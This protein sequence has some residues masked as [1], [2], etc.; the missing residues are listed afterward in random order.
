MCARAA[1][2]FVREHLRV[3][4]CLHVR[5]YVHTYICVSALVSV[6]V[7]VCTVFIVCLFRYLALEARTS[8]IR[9]FTHAITTTRG[10]NE[11][12]R[13]AMPSFHITPYNSRAVSRDN[14]FRLATQILE[15]TG[16]RTWLSWGSKS[17]MGHTFSG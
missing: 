7:S 13:L 17:N 1:D 2:V 6:S 14:L 9:I 11:L 15:A 10:R 8:V 4:R 16:V 3:R 5:V 12:K